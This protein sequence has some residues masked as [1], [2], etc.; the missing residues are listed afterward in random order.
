MKR[1]YLGAL[2]VT[3]GLCLSSAFADDTTTAPKPDKAEKPVKPVKP[4]K[5]EQ[6]AAVKEAQA[7][8]EK[9]REAFLA[10]QKELQAKLKDASKDERTQIREAL[11]QNKETFAAKR[12]DFKDAIKKLH[13]DAPR[14]NVKDD[15][16][17]RPSGKPRH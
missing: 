5:P 3:M 7:N 10:E 6:P 15:K 17:G 16:G 12:E 1:N 8:F 13:D 4:A 14:P 2:I 9:A 11:E